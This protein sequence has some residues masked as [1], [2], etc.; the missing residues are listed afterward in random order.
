M[1]FCLDELPFGYFLELEG[2][3]DPILQA[4]KILGIKQYEEFRTYPTLATELWGTTKD[5]V[6][7][8]FLSSECSHEYGRDDCRICGGWASDIYRVR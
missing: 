7:A 6:E 8:R 3:K 5:I 1:I 4:E 2:E